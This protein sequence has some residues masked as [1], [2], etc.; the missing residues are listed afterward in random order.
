MELIILN[1]CKSKNKLKKLDMIK[2]MI[3]LKNLFHEGKE[4]LDIMRVYYLIKRNFI[5][6][7]LSSVQE[8]I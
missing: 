3:N 8:S 1:G 6:S 5:I 4:M 7:R 2:L